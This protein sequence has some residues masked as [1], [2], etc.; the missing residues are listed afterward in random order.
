MKGLEIDG[1]FA[2]SAAMRSNLPQPMLSRDR[3]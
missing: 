1:F 3:T 2:F